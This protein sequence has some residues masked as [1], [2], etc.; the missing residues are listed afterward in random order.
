MLSDAVREFVCAV[1]EAQ[2]HAD[3]ASAG[4]PS[5]YTGHFALAD[6]VTL[7]S[8]AHFADKLEAALQLEVEDE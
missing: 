2:A 7:A 1:R 5:S 6:V 8:L 4:E 3:A